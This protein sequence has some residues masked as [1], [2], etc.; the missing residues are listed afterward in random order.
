MLENSTPSPQRSQLDCQIRLMREAD[1]PAYK[2]LRDGMLAGHPE[3]F[4]SDARTE[5]LRDA[6]SYRGR[7]SGGDGGANLFTLTA[8]LDGQLVG[9]ISCEHEARVKV[10]H[11]AHIVGMMVSDGLH[12][13]GVGR[14]LLQRALMLLEGEPV[15]E[16]V[17]LS[18]TSSNLAAVRLYES[19]G[20][21]RYGRL[22]GAIKLPD[23]RLVDK[24]LMSRRLR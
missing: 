8:W 10:R 12:G 24:D 17:T 18:V 6:E 21:I 4:T 13:R 23:G 2:Q 22:M 14:Q 3:A 9:A 5:L 16:L 1:L 15:L 19:C 20:F 7:L 11:V